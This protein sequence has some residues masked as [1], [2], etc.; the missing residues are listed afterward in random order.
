[1]AVMLQAVYKQDEGAMLA[2]NDGLEP[3][4][5]ATGN[6]GGLRHVDLTGS[7]DLAALPD[8]I[9]VLTGLR[10]LEIR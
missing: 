5:C 4:A 9:R 8:S 3:P 6:V 1:M 2:S 10:R 7:R